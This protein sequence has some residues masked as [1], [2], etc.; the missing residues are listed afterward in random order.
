MDKKSSLTELTEKTKSVLLSGGTE[1]IDRQHKLKKLTARERVDLILDQASFV[2]LDKYIERSQAT[3]GFESKTSAG[4]GVIT[5]Y[6]TVDGR[7]V[8]VFIQDYTVLSG[9][10]SMA[11]AE[12]ITKI[13]DMALKNGSPVIGVLDSGGSR[14][15]EGAAALAAYGKV[16]K[17][18]N[19]LSGVVPTIAVTAGPCIGAQAYIACLT[20]FTISVSGISSVML[21]G[22]QILS[23]AMGQKFDAEALGGAMAQNSKSGIAQFLAENETQAYATVR[24]LLSY[25]PMNNL[26][27]APYEAS[28]DDVNRQIPELDA[29]E[30]FS[31]QEIIAKIADDG[32]FLEYH[33]YYAPEIIT[34]LA[35]V[36]GNTVGIVANAAGSAISAQAAKK[37]A[38]FIGIL[39]AYHLPVVT[40]VD[41]D[42][43]PVDI[44]TKEPGLISALSSLMYAYAQTSAPM[45]TVIAGRAVAAGL[46]AMGTKSSG[47]DVV[48]AWSNAEISALPIEA[49]SLIFY[50]KEINAAADPMAAKADA[51]EKYKNEYASA[52]N[53]AKQGVVDDVIAPSATRQMIAAALEAC[54]L[55]REN[56]KPPKKHGVLPL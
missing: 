4:E 34:G 42:D 53:A 13:M 38:R 27:D 23:S 11:Q 54:L 14:V 50:E 56:N 25:L 10:M 18:L 29:Q 32:V 31:A 6:G 45:V 19:D 51:L 35:R 3:P 26:D 21:H 9:S 30:A 24:A 52:F 41:A 12:K 49:G 17:K 55:K 43:I 8:Y 33:A 5:G 36:N 2:E 20:D 15:A 48:L 1:Q 7:P 22:E 28:G 16:V 44:E 46:L 47:A 40:L 37:A 39:D